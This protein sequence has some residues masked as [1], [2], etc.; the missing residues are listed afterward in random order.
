VDLFYWGPIARSGKENAM[1]CV[2]REVG[3]AIRIGL[4]DDEEVLVTV[5]R[6]SDA[7]EVE[8][9]FE[10]PRTITL[11]RG[12]VWEAIQRLHQREAT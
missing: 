11:Y 10:A 4:P 5:R 3:Q 9:G 12:E 2:S 6:I 7:G 1:M 8:F